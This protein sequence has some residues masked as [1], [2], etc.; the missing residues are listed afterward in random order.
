MRPFAV[1]CLRASFPR[2]VPVPAS[3][4][5]CGFNAVSGTWRRIVITVMLMVAI[6][7]ALACST[8]LSLGLVSPPLLRTPSRQLAAPTC[9]E[10]HHSRTEHTFDVALDNGVSEQVT[11]TSEED[12]VL[13][14]SELVAKYKLSPEFH[15]QLESDLL[16][17]WFDEVEPDV[18]V[19]SSAEDEPEA[20]ALEP[21]S[22]TL[23]LEGGAS[24]SVTLACE[25]DAL[26]TAA[27]IAKKYGMP[28][29]VREDLEASLLERWFQGDAPQAP[30]YAGPVCETL[31]NVVGTIELPSSGVVLEV[32][33]SAVADGGRGLFI[34][35]ME[36]VESVTLSAGTAVCGYA[37]GAM[38]KAADKAG[39][40][41]V[42]FSLRE[43]GTNVFF[44]QQL[45]TVCR[46]L[47]SPLPAR[48]TLTFTLRLP[49]W[50][51]LVSDRP[52]P[53]R[54]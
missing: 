36:G 38:V 28:V 34:R 31:Q 26:D 37:D 2:V 7:L 47:P 45:W 18:P 42:A 6:V 32:A 9:C 14:A 40:K 22:F 30:V 17:R 44:E 53:S 5:L 33:D 16:N 3:P 27:A 21:I 43:P 8:A 1:G 46:A 51:T 24:E 50:T 35:C 48:P 52:P 4:G 23:D 49:P 25:Q 19:F 29:D 20:P 11:L 13:K 41:T 54:R 39:G 12:A 10:G 15:D